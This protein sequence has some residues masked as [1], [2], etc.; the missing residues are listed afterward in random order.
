[1]NMLSRRRFY[2]T[3]FWIVIEW[4]VGIELKFAGSRRTE[5]STESPPGGGGGLWGENLIEIREER[6]SDEYKLH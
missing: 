1:M 2:K 3:S 4:N 6:K 5:F